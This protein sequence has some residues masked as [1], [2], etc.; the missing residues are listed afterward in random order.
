MAQSGFMISVFLFR[1]SELA[2]AE[3]YR[4]CDADTFSFG[5]QSVNVA[6]KN[7]FQ[8]KLINVDVAP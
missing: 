8:K 5:R 3:T 1:R 4:R 2:L 6:P 7:K